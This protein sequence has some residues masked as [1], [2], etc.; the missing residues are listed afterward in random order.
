MKKIAFCPLLLLHLFGCTHPESGI[1]TTLCK[2]IFNKCPIKDLTLKQ[3]E[4]IDDYHIPAALI[5][6]P[7]I[8]FKN[9]H[10]S[11]LSEDQDEIFTY[12]FFIASKFLTKRSN[13]GIE[14]HSIYSNHF[15]KNGDELENLDIGLKGTF[16]PEKQTDKP[17]YELNAEMCFF[18]FSKWIKEFNSYKP[19]LSSEDCES[20]IP[21]AKMLEN[22]ASI[23]FRNSLS[24]FEY[25]LQEYNENHNVDYNIIINYTPIYS[26][27]F[28]LVAYSSCRFRAFAYQKIMKII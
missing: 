2:E 24:L 21:I 4:R 6:N 20:F 3:L 1:S 9:N 8:I 28:G 10:S 26:K 11:G 25:Q 16:T 12:V 13:D 17:S 15:E 5:S 19:R 27:I 22:E 18:I 23:F 14:P 7:Q